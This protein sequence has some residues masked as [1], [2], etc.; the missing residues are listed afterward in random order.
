VKTTR[1][2]IGITTNGRW[3]MYYKLRVEYV[4]TTRRAGGIPVMLPP[5][6]PDLDELLSRLDGI[7]FSGG[8]DVDPR[9]YRGQD[10]HETLS[11]IDYERDE[12]ESRLI[13]KLMALELPMLFICRGIQMLN[14]VL[15]GSLLSHVPDTVGEEI[16]HRLPDK[17]STPHRVFVEPESRL[18]KIMGQANVSTASWH[19]QAVREVADGFNI[20]ARA[21]DGIIEALELPDRPGLVA[22]QWHPELTAENDPSQQRLF[23]W[24]VNAAR[25][26]RKGQ[27]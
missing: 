5:G 24:L 11:R 13:R 27:M 19:H 17:G 16:L 12:T 6:E 25:E 3:E 9:L 26:F 10:V 4:D 1:P 23:D 18:A 15:G 2:L 7:I 8:L 14:V 21:P 20:I 22:V